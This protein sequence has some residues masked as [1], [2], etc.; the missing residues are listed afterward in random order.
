MGPSAAWFYEGQLRLHRN[1]NDKGSGRFVWY[2]FLV[3]PHHRGAQVW[4]AFSRHHTVLPATH[5]FI[6]RLNE[7]Y[8]PL[9]SQPK[10]VLIYRSQRDGRLSWPRHHHGESAQDRSMTE[11]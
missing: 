4:H 2:L 1:N 5:T 9:P 11:I 8:L 6:H 3:R 7:P 10:L